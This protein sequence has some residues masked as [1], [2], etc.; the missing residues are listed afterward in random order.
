MAPFSAP[1]FEINFTQAQI[2]SLCQQGLT[3]VNVAYLIGEKR[4]VLA[5]VDKA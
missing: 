5:H 1:N 3:R 4:G 2:L